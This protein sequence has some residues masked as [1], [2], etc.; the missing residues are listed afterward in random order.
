MPASSL[1]SEGIIAIIAEQNGNQCV[2]KCNS[3]DGTG[4]LGGMMPKPN[5]TI[6]IHD[7]LQ[8]MACAGRVKRPCNLHLGKQS[9]EN[10]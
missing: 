5:S 6:L 3:E 8:T 9:P 4:G 1:H 7:L 2:S 10:M